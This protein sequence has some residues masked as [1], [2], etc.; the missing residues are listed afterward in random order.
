MSVSSKLP[1][2]ENGPCFNK[3]KIYSW[4]CSFCVENR[5]KD[6]YLYGVGIIASG[7]TLHISSVDNWFWA[8]LWYKSEIIV[9]WIYHTCS[10]V[11]NCVGL[12]WEDQ[13][14]KES[15]GNGGV[16]ELNL[17]WTLFV[18]FFTISSLMLNKLWLICLHNFIEEH[19]YFG[20]QNKAKGKPNLMCY[21]LIVM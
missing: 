4:N 3:L 18:L 21:I 5:K 6:K 11:A 7:A 9:F 15:E 13:T 10:F 19:S 2:G 12:F 1:V 16:K 20:H 8:P 17:W 14:P